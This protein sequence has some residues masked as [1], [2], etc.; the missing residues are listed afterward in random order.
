MAILKEQTKEYLNKF[1]DNTGFYNL[2]LNPLEE[3]KT[4]FCTSK[5]LEVS[6][7]YEDVLV[8]N[9][10]I[11]YKVNDNDWE[12]HEYPIYIG[13]AE[14]YNYYIDRIIYTIFM[15]INEIIV[16]DKEYGGIGNFA[17]EGK[18]VL[19]AS[20]SGILIEDAVIIQFK[21]TPF[22]N[23]LDVA[24]ILFNNSP[25]EANWFVCSCGLNNWEASE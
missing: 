6:D 2:L 8:H 9:F 21:R 15:G 19:A 24:P 11:T 23:S 4:I 17:V 16:V 14:I 20:N 10:V 12:T 18:S 3:N 25:D 5:G 13:S 7:D 22:S 1:R